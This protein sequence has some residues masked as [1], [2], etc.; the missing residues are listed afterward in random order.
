VEYRSFTVVI[1]ASHVE[2]YQSH[3]QNAASE[4]APENYLS[5]SKT[6]STIILL[7]IH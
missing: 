6:I 1:I 7:T 5:A 3:D 2:I 4:T